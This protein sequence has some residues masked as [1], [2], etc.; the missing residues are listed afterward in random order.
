MSVAFSPLFL[1]SAGAGRY[2]R[3]LRL[4]L[5][6]A[7]R[8]RVV[9]PASAPNSTP[10][11]PT[12]RP[13]PSLPPP[14]FSPHPSGNGNGNGS[15]PIF[16]PPAPRPSFDLVGNGGGGAGIEI[17]LTESSPSGS[18]LSFDWTYAEDLLGSVGMSVHEGGALPLWLSDSDLGSNQLLSGGMEV[19]RAL[20]LPFVVHL[21]PI[22][23]LT[24][25]LLCSQDFFLPSDIDLQLDLYS[26][27][28]SSQGGQLGDTPGPSSGGGVSPGKFAHV[29]SSGLGSSLGTGAT[30]G[31]GWGAE[32]KG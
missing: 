30:N 26:V 21:K 31:G 25:P 23:L 28:G 14:S 6:K 12:S 29:D 3:S 27:N 15:L 2:A 9:P 8:R 18:L 1:C 16:P 5:R 17:G 20:L 10:G 19:G 22:P 4:M 32:W 13:P 24:Q 7:R 11:S